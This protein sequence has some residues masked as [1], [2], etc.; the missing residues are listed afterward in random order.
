MKVESC[1]WH[2]PRQAY[3]RYLHDSGVEIDEL[4]TGRYFSADKEYYLDLSYKGEMRFGPRYF[5][6]QIR[7][8][9]DRL[10]RDFKKRTFGVP[11][12]FGRESYYWVGSPWSPSSRHIALDE[13]KSGNASEFQLVIYD[14]DSGEEVIA[15]AKKLDN[16][17]IN[18]LDAQLNNEQ[19]MLKTSTLTL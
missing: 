4:G 10:I 3:E 8:K 9:D 5:S 2:K 1:S 16:F 14:L 6:V 12:S 7:D 17:L 18:Q 19:F 15:D 13:F 11:G